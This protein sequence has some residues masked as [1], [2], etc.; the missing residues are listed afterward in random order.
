VTYHPTEYYASAED[1]ARGRDDETVL[2]MA[3]VLW[4]EAGAVIRWESA[5]PEVRD[6]YVAKALAELGE[7]FDC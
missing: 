7:I 5:H 6:R 1:I 2:N 4:Y 3:A